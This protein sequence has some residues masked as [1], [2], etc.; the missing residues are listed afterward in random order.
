MIKQHEFNTEWWGK[1]VGIV[2]DPAFFRQPPAD[3]HA[4]LQQFAWT[5]FVQPVSKLPDRR[6]MADA[7][8]FYADTQVRFRIDLSHIK[9]GPCASA[10]EVEIASEAPFSIHEGDLKTFP[11]ERFYSLPGAT[12]TRIN[13]RYVRWSNNLIRQHPATC[14][15]FL[16]AG[17]VQGWF[18]SHPESGSIDL[19]L[20]M[21]SA[22]AA[23]SGFDVYS[24][25]LAEYARRG[26]RLGAASFSARNSPVHNIYSA[27]G[28]RYLEPRECWIW[29]RD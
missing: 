17:Q 4:V 23:A 18:L 8:F 14:F 19:T 11:Y 28:A 15:R 24:R 7:G 27:L 1:E 13:A 10:L 20:A 5:E 12:E 26:F 22:T 3:Q 25:A 29:I 6:S 2:T 16:Q 9:P 21:L